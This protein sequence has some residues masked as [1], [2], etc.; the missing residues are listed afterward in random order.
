MQ[1]GM[2][3]HLHFSIDGA[4]LRDSEHVQNVFLAVSVRWVAGAN[5]EQFGT[6]WGHRHDSLPVN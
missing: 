1:T 5:G 3:L 6:E 4:E 2:P